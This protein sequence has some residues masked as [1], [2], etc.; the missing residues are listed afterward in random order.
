MPNTIETVSVPVEDKVN[1]RKL[2]RR[3]DMR[4]KMRMIQRMA[5]SLNSL[6]TPHLRKRR[7][8]RMKRRRKK[9]RKKR[10]K[11][12]M[13]KRMKKRKRK[14]RKRRDQRRRQKL[15]Q[16]PSLQVMPQLTMKTGGYKGCSYKTFLACN[17]RDY[18]GKGGAVALTR[19]I[20]KIESV[21]ARGHEAAIGMSWVDFKAL[22]VEEF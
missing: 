3:M 18:D 17:S 1:M 16:T 13:K 11:N 5:Q 21:Q 2:V 20:K 7:K 19:W 8:K 9:R 15:G 10:R 12:R 14:G 6:D 22:L 4:R